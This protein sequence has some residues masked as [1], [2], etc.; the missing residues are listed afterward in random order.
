MNQEESGLHSFRIGDQVLYKNNQLIAFN[1]PVMLPVQPDKT[2]D[3]SLLELAEMYAHSK[4]HLVHRIDRPA[5]GVVL[6]AKNT[7][8][9]AAL[10]EQFRLREVEK[11]Y[12]AVVQQL[13]PEQSGQL[14]HYLV[15]NGR[16][17]R[18]SLTEESVPGAQEAV[19]DYRVLGSSDRYHLLEIKLH[20][21]RHHQIRAQLAAIGCPIKGDVKYGFRRNNPGGGI[22][23]HAWKLS[24]RHP[25]SNELVT[26]VAPIP[27]DDPVWDALKP[28]E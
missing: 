10:H 26:L 2:G 13:P 25:V 22:H 9:L 4:L 20:T 27:T 15:K 14:R 19:L 17:N 18:S 11:T 21:G 12:L 7:T 5:G 3:K 28:A 1:K 23:L 16:T 24:F 6:F 8:A